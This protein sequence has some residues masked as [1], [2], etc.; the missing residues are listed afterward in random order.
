LLR[1]GVGLAP[2]L[3]Q[4][5]GA[6]QQLPRKPARGAG[7]LGREL[8]P[9]GRA[10]LTVLSL[11]GLGR[12]LQDPVDLVLELGQGAVGAIGGVGG[13]L[14]PVQSDQTQVDQPGRRAQPQRLDQEPGQRL[15]VAGTEARDGHVVGHLVASESTEGEVLGAAPLDLPRRTHSGRVG[16]QQHAQQR[17]GVVGGMAVPIAA[18]GT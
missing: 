18:V 9:S 3:E 13:H 2:E 4:V 10:V 16:V 6:A 7:Q 12:L 5:V 14:G 1:L 11:I 17:L 8:I 15:L